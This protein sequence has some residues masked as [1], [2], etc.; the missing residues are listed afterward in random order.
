[1]ISEQMLL[2]MQRCFR[3][4]LSLVTIAH[5]NVDFCEPISISDVFVA[6]RGGILAL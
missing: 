1:M 3:A 2:L 6:Y 4:L 5:L